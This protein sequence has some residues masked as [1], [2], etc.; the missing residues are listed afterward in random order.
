MLCGSFITW[1]FILMLL[2]QDVSV[3]VAIIV[4]Y[5]AV[6]I[7][8]NIRNGIGYNGKDGIILEKY[9]CEVLIPF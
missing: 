8:W 6:H 2:P 7:G 3:T 9:V 5:L 4:S 1:S